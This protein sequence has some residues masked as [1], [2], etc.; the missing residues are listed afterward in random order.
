MRCVSVVTGVAV[1]VGV[2][3]VGAEAA[4]ELERACG[5]AVAFAPVCA[6][7]AHTPALTNRPAA[8]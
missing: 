4:D 1:G 7:H 3:A 2:V 6:P 8:N 5:E